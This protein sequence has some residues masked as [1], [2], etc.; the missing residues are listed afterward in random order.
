VIRSLLSGLAILFVTSSVALAAPDYRCIIKEVAT[1]NPSSADTFTFN[2]G[3]EFTVER[4][5][6]VIAGAVRN[7]FFTD[8][9]VVDPGSDSNAYKVV[10]T[11]RLGE[12]EGVGSIATLL[13]INEYEDTPEKAFLFADGDVAYFGSCVHF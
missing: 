3:R 2:I 6:G 12:G 1:A 11:L 10:S 7:R 9:V 13:T 5:S 4:R 8:P